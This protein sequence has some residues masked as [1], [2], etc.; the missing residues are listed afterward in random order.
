MKSRTVSLTSRSSPIGSPG[1]NS[2]HPSVP[3][4]MGESS[5]IHD[6]PSKPSIAAAPKA[7]MAL[8]L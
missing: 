5:E 4:R 7:V 2:S 6:V 1:W 8:H 3:S